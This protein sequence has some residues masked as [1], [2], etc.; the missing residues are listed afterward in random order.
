MSK[1]SREKFKL[2]HPEGRK[3]YA[4]KRR[5]ARNKKKQEK[6]NAKT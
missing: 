3:E 6:R 2:E 1:S 4:R 5:L